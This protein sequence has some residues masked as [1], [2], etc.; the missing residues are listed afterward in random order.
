MHELTVDVISVYCFQ[1]K[2]G[3]FLGFGSELNVTRQIVNSLF[4]KMAGSDPEVQVCTR[5]DCRNF[6]VMDCRGTNLC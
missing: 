3:S 6:H 2:V 4:S 5:L 1:A